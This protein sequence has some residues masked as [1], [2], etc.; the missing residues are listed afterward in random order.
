M[1]AVR[2]IKKKKQQQTFIE[3][4]HMIETEILTEALFLSEHPF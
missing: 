3:I 1:V 4:V 2:E